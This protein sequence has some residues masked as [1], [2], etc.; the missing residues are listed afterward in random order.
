[1]EIILNSSNFKKEVLES[2]EGVLVDFWAPWC[3][4]CRILGPVIEELSEEWS[5]KGVKICKVN[6]DE[7]S[8]LAGQYGV[9]SI[10]TMVF[11]KN[12]KAVGQMVGAQ[13]KEKIEQELK[14]YF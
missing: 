2:K 8:A 9:M 6:V 5:G 13:P 14:K 11:F 12:G 1:M 7:E 4:P 3:G 10:P